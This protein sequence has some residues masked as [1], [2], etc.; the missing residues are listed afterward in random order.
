M[1]S[2]RKRVKFGA[3]T[4]RPEALVTLL[5]HDGISGFHLSFKKKSLRRVSTYA[6]CH[7]SCI[8]FDASFGVMRPQ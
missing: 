7:H 5:L 6:L 4:A 2:L 1:A 3:G 8:T